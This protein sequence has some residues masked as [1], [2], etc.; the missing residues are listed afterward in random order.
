MYN[1]I[2]ITPQLVEKFPRAPCFVLVFVRKCRAVKTKDLCRDVIVLTKLSSGE[3]SQLRD[4]KP[5]QN[6]TDWGRQLDPETARS[7][8]EM[9]ARGWAALLQPGDRG[10]PLTGDGRSSPRPSTCP[11]PGHCRAQP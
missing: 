9:Q 11:L 7:V 8:A 6:Q 3:V 2:N 1:L 4:G 5:D 10:H